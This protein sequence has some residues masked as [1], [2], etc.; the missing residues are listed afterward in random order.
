MGDN[1]DLAE[2]KAE[3]RHMNSTMADIADNVKKLTDFMVEQISHEAGA[4]MLNTEDHYKVT[5]N[6]LRWSLRLKRRVNKQDLGWP[7]E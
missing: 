2:L 1:N 4:P 7:D 3:Q 5:P 6:D